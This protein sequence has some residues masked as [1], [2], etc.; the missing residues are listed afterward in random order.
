MVSP[1]NPN[2]GSALPPLHQVNE[3]LSVTG[4][5]S[6]E[7]VA[8]LAGA[9]FRSIICNRPDG[10]AMGQPT[11]AEIEA[12]AAQAGLGFRFIPV[13][14]GQILPE[15]VDAFADAMQELPGPVLAYCAAGVRSSVLARA[16]GV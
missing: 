4:Q 3:N 16:A 13:S 9:G 2:Q 12:A 1:I 8:A 15:S 14:G 5:I 6:P 10:E 7:A 11:A